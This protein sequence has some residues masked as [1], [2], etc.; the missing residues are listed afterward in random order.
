MALSMKKCFDRMFLSSKAANRKKKHNAGVSIAEVVIAMS[1]IAL[2]SAVAISAVRVSSKA[3][4]NDFS[5]VEMRT[6]ASNNIEFFKSSNNLSDLQKKITTYSKAEVLSHT[7]Q[8]DG[9]YLIVETT[10]LDEYVLTTEIVYT[11]SYLGDSN[12]TVDYQYSIPISI[13]VICNNTSGA[14]SFELRCEK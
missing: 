10:T 8:T 2:V 5:S 7:E 14:T 13:H 1:I 6:Y 12:Q 3:L 9:T 4:S 11:P